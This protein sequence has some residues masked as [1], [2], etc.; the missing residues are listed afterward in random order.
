MVSGLR[1]ADTYIAGRYTL[2]LTTFICLAENL[3]QSLK[4]D[5]GRRTAKSV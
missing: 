1:R 2:D 4:P 5:A 3:G